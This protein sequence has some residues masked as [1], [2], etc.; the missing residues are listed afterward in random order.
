MLLPAN[1]TRNETS[2]AAV[3][4]SSRL[5]SFRWQAA[6]IALLIL[7]AYANSLPSSF[8]FDDHSIFADPAMVSP[9]FGWDAFR[10]DRTRPL[11]Y[12]TFHWN[13]LLGG[14]NPVL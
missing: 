8:H 11:T 12:L 14:E 4:A 1:E 7:L 5:D 3:A 13:Y 9:G 2:T 10:L 6:A